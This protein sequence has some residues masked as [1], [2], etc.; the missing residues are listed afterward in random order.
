MSNTLF[1]G[2]DGGATKILAQICEFDLESSLIT[3]IGKQIEFSYGDSSNFDPTF[4]PTELLK[5]QKESK[6][7]IF[8]FSKKEIK[9]SSSIIDTIVKIILSSVK[10]TKITQIGLCFPGIKTTNLDGISIMVN[11]PRNIDMLNE[12]NQ[13]IKSKLGNK[14]SIKMI[15][16]DSECCVIGEKKSSV[17][18]LMNCKNAIYIGGGTGIADGLI[19]N[20]KI[21]NLKN[22]SEIKRSWELI[23]HNGETIETCLSL[24]GMLS[25]WEKM[26]KDSPL[27]IL[28]LFENAMLDDNIA[29]DILD[30]A[31]NAFTFLI[32]D[33]TDFFYSK[34]TK[35]EKIVIGQRLGLLLSNKNNPLLK[36]ISKNYN[37]QIPIE[38][39]TDRRT[40]AIGAAYKAYEN[41]K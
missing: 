34:N 5:Q 38:I 20:N 29:N 30:K 14:L 41:I 10:N 33:R 37:G 15:Y 35:P 39:S 3:P 8:N 23:M 13:K 6:N 26:K 1:L 25:K 11:G 28:S 31:A 40:A 32:K 24:G 36:L 7:N 21:I 17:G 9:Q 27:N 22:H 4:K 19:L 12:L 2:L 18:K 16:D